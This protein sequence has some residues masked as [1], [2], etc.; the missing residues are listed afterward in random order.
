M[1][2]ATIK[3]EQLQVNMQTEREI[4][5]QDELTNM[6]A[7]LLLTFRKSVAEAG[8]Y[9]ALADNDAPIILIN[10]LNVYHLENKRIEKEKT[11]QKVIGFNPNENSKWQS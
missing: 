11:E 1:I 10:A 6:I 4:P 8:A 3:S 5:I 2:N 7:G 9:P